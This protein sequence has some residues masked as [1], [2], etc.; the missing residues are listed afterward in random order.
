M[1]PPEVEASLVGNTVVGSNEVQVSVRAFGKLW[2]IG[3][4][5]DER[6]AWSETVA[7][8]RGAPPTHPA[9]D[10]KPADTKLCDTRNARS[11]ATA[12]GTGSRSFP[13]SFVVGTT[14]EPDYHEQL[15]WPSLCL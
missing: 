9:S 15:P 14:R 7:N 10:W 6:A 3:R 13:F 12:F 5:L 2:R 1:T 11:Y 4:N 8:Y